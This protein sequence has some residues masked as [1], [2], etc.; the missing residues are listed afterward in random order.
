MAELWMEPAL[1]A[2]QNRVGRYALEE[3]MQSFY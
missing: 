1:P 2:L 3:Y